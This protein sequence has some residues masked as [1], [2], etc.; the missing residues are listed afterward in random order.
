MTRAAD[1]AARIRLLDWDGLR[2]LWDRSARGPVPGWPAGKA[3]EH[4]VLRAFELDGATVRWPFEVRLGDSVIEQIDG[5]V[6]A[7]HL[8]CVVEAKD[9][10]D[11][12]DIGA[13]AK[14]RTQLARRPGGTIGV[15]FSRSGFTDPAIALAGYFA[16]QTV[17]LWSGAEV[18]ECLENESFAVVLLA[19]HRECVEEGAPKTKSF[20]KIR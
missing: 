17:L 9:T 13:L 11:A 16:P 2:D 12:V 6:Y 5:A 20:R 15:V 1:Y 7:G 14:I 19:K 18:T 8:S 10:A 4:L 3:F